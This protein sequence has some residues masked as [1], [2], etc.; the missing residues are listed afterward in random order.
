MP[1]IV[2]ITIDRN[3]SKRGSKYSMSIL[4]FYFDIFIILYKAHAKILSAHN[5]VKIDR[6]TKRKNIFLIINFKNE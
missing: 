6:K 5:I 1:P 3:T 2:L 4:N